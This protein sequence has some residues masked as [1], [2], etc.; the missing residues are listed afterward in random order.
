M[1]SLN[2]FDSGFPML[3]TTAANEH[4]A[5]IERYIR[6]VKEWTKS[7]YTML[8]YCH[9]PQIV[10]IHLVKNAVFWLNVFP[11]DDGMSKKYSPCYIMTS[12]QLSYVKHAVIEF[13]LYVQ[14]HEEHLNNMDQHTTGCICLVPTG[15]Q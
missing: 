8:P 10:L 5:D 7:R 9:L 11:T 13:G 6:T 1:G 3:N 12:Q 15:N 4:V 14:T 2:C